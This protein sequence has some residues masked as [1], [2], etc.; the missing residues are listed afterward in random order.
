MVFDVTSFILRRRAAAGR[1]RTVAVDLEPLRRV[2]DRLDGDF[3]RRRDQLIRMR[4]N[5]IANAAFSAQALENEEIG[6]SGSRLKSLSNSI[7]SMS[8]QI[9]FVGRELSFVEQ[10]IS[11]LSMFAEESAATQDAQ[12]DIGCRPAGDTT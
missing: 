6:A 2:L 3:R 12:P 7:E 11:S 10:A 5:L 9:K 1:S 4:E 8:M